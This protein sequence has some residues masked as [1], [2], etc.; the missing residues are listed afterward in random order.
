MHC[1]K[2]GLLVPRELGE[3]PRVVGERVLVLFLNYKCALVVKLHKQEFK[4]E[5][6]REDML[7]ER[8]KE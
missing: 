7:I 2:S 1:R 4:N 5:L 3:I 8:E 6:G